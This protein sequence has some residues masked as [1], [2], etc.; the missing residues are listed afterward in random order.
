MSN[1]SVPRA[2]KSESKRISHPWVVMTAL[3]LSAAITVG[4]SFG[5]LGS[6][7]LGD[8]IGAIGHA[9]RT[10]THPQM[11]DRAAPRFEAIL[12]Q[13]Q[14]T[15]VE[16]EGNFDVV[17][18]QLNHVSARIPA[19]QMPTQNEVGL[20]LAKLDAAFVRAGTDI[21]ELQQ[22]QKLQSDTQVQAVA[23]LT[24]RVDQLETR[25]AARE[26]TGTVANPKPAPA[27]L[28][29]S[30]YRL[31]GKGTATI[32]SE[33]GTIAVKRGDVVIGLGRI[34]GFKQRRGRWYVV[35]EKGLIGQH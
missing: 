2:A 25:F 27:A 22:Q 33:R 5:S 1:S 16:L 17:K 13:L 24:K 4:A 29:W 23:N 19:D 30:L 34:K 9:S 8:I 7:R 32:V 35:S 12:Q 11:A 28:H 26:I 18:A 6:G 21:A 3:A 14:R 15:V 31:T 20:R 10:E